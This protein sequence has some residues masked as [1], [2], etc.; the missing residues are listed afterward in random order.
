MRISSDLVEV[1]VPGTLLLP[2]KLGSAVSLFDTFAIR[3]IAGETR[4]AIHGPGKGQP[5]DERNLVVRAL[6]AT[7]EYA[8][9]PLVGVDL[10]CRNSIPRGANL[11]EDVAAVAAGISAAWALL[12]HESGPSENILSEIGA[13]F[14]VDKVRLGAAFAGGVVLVGKHVVTVGSPDWRMTAFIPNYQVSSRRRSSVSQTKA[15]VMAL[16]CAGNEQAQQ[17]LFWATEP[18]DIVAVQKVSPASVAFMNWLREKSIPA[19]IPECGPVVISLAE[20][21]NS[22]SSAAMK[23]GWAVQ[24]LAVCADG[25]AVNNKLL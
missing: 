12:G 17:Q 9:A 19:Y 15:A 25:L 11:G 7:L 20:V 23:S 14:S 6:H 22:I 21:D 18:E 13:Q 10:V 24:E 3:A 2:G 5:R 8:G 4:V 1:Q 16:A